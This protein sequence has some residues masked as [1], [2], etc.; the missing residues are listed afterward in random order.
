MEVVVKVPEGRV[1]VVAI[2][3]ELFLAVRVLCGVAL[4][5]AFVVPPALF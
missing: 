4:V 3:I 5:G 2:G 1:L